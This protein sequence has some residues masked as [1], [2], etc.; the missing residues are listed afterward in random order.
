MINRNAKAIG[1]HGKSE[2]IS[3]KM[4][5]FVLFLL[6]ILRLFQI[7]RKVARIIKEFLYT[8]HPDSLAVK[9][10]TPL[11]SFSFPSQSFYI[12]LAISE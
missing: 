10:L 6:F 8:L 5:C 1:L 9:N 3:S 2:I 7:H 12:Y 11:L 4:F